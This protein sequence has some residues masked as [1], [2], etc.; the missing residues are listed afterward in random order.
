MLN[1]VPG[2]L[3]SATLLLPVLLLTACASKPFLSPEPV[4]PPSAPPLPL[5]ARQPA[6]DPICLPT[7]SAAL[8]SA[9]TGWR[10]RLT[11]PASPASSASAP[12]TP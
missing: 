10:S 9:L 11:A 2:N 8:Q 7:C 12:T 6:T 1:S 4:A 5:A 3:R